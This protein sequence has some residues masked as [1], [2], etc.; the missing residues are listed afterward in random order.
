MR[1]LSVF[2]DEYGDTSISTEKEGV[3]NFYILTAVLLPTNA[4][5][6]T[7]STV[8][9]IRARF[10]QT[11][12]M[13]SSKIGKDD[14]KRLNVLGALNELDFKTY[15]IA[16]D[17]R[18]LSKE[19]GLA[20]KKSFFKYVNRLL[21]N[22]LYQSFDN[23]HV[24]ADEHGREE[25]MNSFKA[26][27]EKQLSPSLF[28]NRTFAFA[29]SCDDP[30]LQVPDIVSGTLARSFDPAKSS[31]RAA[32]FQKLVTERSV[33]INVW[34]PRRLPKPQATLGDEKQN[35]DDLICSHCFQLA[36]TFLEKKMVDDEEAR[37]QVGI[38]QFLLFYA[39]FVDRTAFISTPKI[40]RYLRDDLG[41]EMNEYRLRVSGIAPL[42]DADV[43]VASS[44]KGYKI[45][46]C[47][48]DLTKFVEHTNTIVPPMLA[49]LNRARNELKLVSLGELDILDG[50]EH[51]YLRN[52]L[53]MFQPQ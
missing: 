48:S 37:I 10:F 23:I 17:K 34:P 5:Q 8:E 46:V 25:F 33:G 15:S 24:T 41:I 11:G 38:L 43:I 52:L 18:E 27:I 4:V 14:Q 31:P 28:A 16:V 3:S 51:R 40:I 30:L 19:S 2:I 22:R 29:K 47:A 12:E 53:D 44:T 7:R 39:Q 36:E 26:Y 42:R 1:D 50:E 21:Y 13:K 49:R 6:S 32:E 45:P 9:A 20:Y 35:Y